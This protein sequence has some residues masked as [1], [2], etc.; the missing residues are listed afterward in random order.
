[1][2]GQEGRL[3][4]PHPHI[5]HPSRLYGDVRANSHG[6]D[7][8]NEH[9]L[10]SLSSALLSS[11][12]TRAEAVPM[13]GCPY[14]ES[15]SV[16]AVLNPADHSDQVGTVREASIKDVDNALNCAMAA[17]P[18]WQSTLPEERAAI[19]ERAANLMEDQMQSLMGLLV[20]EAGKTFANAISEVREAVDFLR[21]YAMQVRTHFSNDTH[22]PLGPVVC[23][24]PWNFPLA[25]FSGQIAAALAAGNT[26]L[27][28]PAEQTS[29]IAA[30]GIRILLDAGVPAGAVQLLPGR[31]ETVGARLVEDERVRGVMFTGSTEVARI[32]QRSIARRLDA[33]GRAIPLIAETGGMNA[34][35]VDSSALSEQVVVDVIASAFDSAGQ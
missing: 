28:K 9:R 12:Q 32:L 15:T 8:S 26:V 10:A 11:A 14:D 21:Y 35:I 16:Q 5:A 24:S 7:L 30:A 4:L 27:A 3:G 29:L 20:R 2:A 34:M 22:R 33:Q 19:L 18:I 13:L 6:L 23:I 1:L 25:I 17:A 31:G